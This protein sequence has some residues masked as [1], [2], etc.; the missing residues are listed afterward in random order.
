MRGDEVI[1]RGDVVVTDG[2]IVG[3]GP[4][5]SVDVPSNARVI[6]VSGKVI[7]PGFIDIHAHFG[8]RGE[9]L[10]PEGTFSFANLA[11]GITTVRNPQASV[12]VF[13]LADAIE[14]DG[15]PAPR[16]VSTGPGLF[17]FLNL[18]S[19]EQTLSTHRRYR[20]EYGTRVLKSYLVGDRQQ[21]QWVVQASRELGMMPTT[22]GGAD[23]KAKGQH[24]ANHVLAAIN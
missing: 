15:V 9:Q 3:V 19:Y 8:A 6:D 4:T 13:E 17:Q 2:R 12:D 16:V 18:E 23:T 5:G 1:D 7:A 11:F 14:A 21:R 20:D 10:E 24:A 22:E